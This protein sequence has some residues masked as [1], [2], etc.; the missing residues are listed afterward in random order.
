[1]KG[2]ARDSGLRPGLAFVVKIIATALV[3]DRHGAS[4]AMSAAGVDIER[5]P[6]EDGSALSDR[7]DQG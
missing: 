1:V 6:K 7:D 5:T 3:R 4:G 2:S